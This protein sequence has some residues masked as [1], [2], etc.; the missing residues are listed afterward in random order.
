VTVIH[1][2]LLTPVQPHPVATV[3][4]TLPVPPVDVR[5]CDVGDT[6][7][8]HVGAKLNVFDKGLAEL[9][10]G[11]T[12]ATSATYT[13]PGT[14]QPTNTDVRSTWMR[15]SELGAGFPNDTVW[16]GACAPERKR[17]S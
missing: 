1:D 8:E 11:P 7:N 13:V 4:V 10:P 5:L 12:A 3:T 9:P 2:A 17:P 14:G 16:N 15:P 6:L